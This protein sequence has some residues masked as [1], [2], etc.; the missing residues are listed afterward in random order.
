MAI[1]IVAYDLNK[2]GQDYE[3]LLEKLAT[4]DRFHAQGSV[5]LLNSNNTAEQ[6]RDDL[7]KHL[8][9]NDK[10]IVSKMGEAAWF[11]YSAEVSKWINNNVNV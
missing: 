3:A 6:I 10:L 8:D 11:G 9:S 5:W 1:H 7:L 2:P 4:Y